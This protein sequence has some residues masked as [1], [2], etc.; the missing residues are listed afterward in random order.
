MPKRK[1]VSESDKA[2]KKKLKSESTSTSKAFVSKLSFDG[3]EQCI[4]SLIYPTKLEDF[5]AKYWEKEPLFVSRKDNDYFKGFPTKVKL[6]EIGKKEHLEWD[7]DLFLSQVDNGEEILDAEGEATVHKIQKYLKEKLTIVFDK[8]HRFQEELYHLLQLLEEYFGCLLYCSLEVHSENAYK[9]KP[10]YNGKEAFILQIEGKKRWCLYE[11]IQKL[12]FLDCEDLKQDE[13][14]GVTHEFILEPGD[15]LYF[16]RGTVFQAHSLNDEVSGH[17]EIQL[18]EEHT[19]G[20]FMSNI[21]DKAINEALKKDVAFREALPTNFLSYMEFGKKEIS[22]DDLMDDAT[23]QANGAPKATVPK[24]SKADLENQELFKGN[25]Q[26]LTS[27]VGQYLDPHWGADAFFGK[28][29]ITKRLA[30]S[31]VLKEEQSD[32]D[33]TPP[34]D[35]SV[36]QMKH[37]NYMRITKYDPGEDWEDEHEEDENDENEQDEESMEEEEDEEKMGNGKDES[38]VKAKSDSKKEKKRKS[39]G[40]DD[41]ENEEDLE[42]SFHSKPCIVLYHCLQNKIESDYE[43]MDSSEMETEGSK[44]EFPLHYRD[45]LLILYRSTAPVAVCNLPLTSEERVDLATTLWCEGL[46]TIVE[47]S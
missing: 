32:K 23:N 18:Y 16:P 45:A 35:K 11:P 34:S 6:E 14:G 46:L 4:R 47:K 25:L 5:F 7:K 33:E 42:K 10:C 36:V 19:W 8:P 9:R 17:I 37:R 2:P 21:L 44:I 15:L 28:D 40:K 39:G 43:E 13:I 24:I 12:A 22:N 31:Q 29:F 3:P 20:H 26:R 30:P 1:V 38:S 27:L 41:K